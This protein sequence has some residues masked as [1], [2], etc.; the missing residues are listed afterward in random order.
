MFTFS[1][2]TSTSIKTRLHADKKQ[3]YKQSFVKHGASTYWGWVAQ[4]FEIKNTAYSIL[5]VDILR[6]I[7]C[8]FWYKLW[9]VSIDYIYSPLS[10]IFFKKLTLTFNSRNTFEQHS[11]VTYIRLSVIIEGNQTSYQ[12]RISS[13]V[14]R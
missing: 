6:D 4:A 12:A 8:I 13:L 2:I 3:E 14:Y 7:I 1:I 9:I 5:T 10:F 11:T